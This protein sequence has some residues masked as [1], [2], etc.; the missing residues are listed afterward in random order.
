MRHNTLIS[1]RKDGKMSLAFFAA[2]LCIF[3]FFLQSGPLVSGYAQSQNNSGSGAA[4]QSDGG[5]SAADSN[6]VPGAGFGE[7][8]FGPQVDEGSA[9]WEI[10]KVIF[11]LGLF[12]GGF[13]FFYKFIRQKVGINISGQ[14][15]IRTLSMVPVGPNKTLQII[16]VAG[17][18][19]LI[20]VTDSSINMITEIK[21]KDDIDRIRLLSSRSTPVQGKNFQE[22]VADQMGWI[23]DKINEKRVHGFRKTRVE[24]ISEKDIDMSYLD[25]QKKRLKKI[26]HE[27][28]E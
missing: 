28:E 18:V 12:G 4:V 9:F 22:F 25:N 8:D 19:F 6:A 20:G 23:I 2:I 10:I 21:E 7:G 17:K 14:E 1:Y 27:D 16:D 3:M 11:V 26:N 13:Y 24:E 15:A 5:G